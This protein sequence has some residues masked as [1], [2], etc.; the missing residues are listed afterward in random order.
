VVPS[1]AIVAYSL[2]VAGAPL[3][4]AAVVATARPR[5]ASPPSLATYDAIR[6][7]GNGS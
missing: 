7:G 3:D 1:S 6:S 2:M 4:P 5:T